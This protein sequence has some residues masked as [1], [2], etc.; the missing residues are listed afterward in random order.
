[1]SFDRSTLFS[2]ILAESQNAGR[3]IPWERGFFADA[4]VVYPRYGTFVTDTNEKLCYWQGLPK[5]LN[6]EG[7]PDFRNPGQFLH[8]TR[9]Y[10]RRVEQNP[11]DNDAR[12]YLANCYG[13]LSFPTAPDHSMSKP[14]LATRAVEIYD[15]IINN[16]NFDWE[17]ADYHDRVMGMTSE[18]YRS[19]F[20]ALCLEATFFKLRDSAN[21]DLRQHFLGQLR[22]YVG[23]VALSSNDQAMLEETIHFLENNT[24]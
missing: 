7:L 13:M 12:I 20:R 4:Q 16:H 22:S 8:A 1:M 17:R 3:P 23:D 6:V 19:R 9:Y 14:L 18:N 11:H 15:S 21:S 10:E 5:G 2:S 24:H